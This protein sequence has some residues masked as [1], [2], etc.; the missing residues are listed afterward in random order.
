M[1]DETV[2]MQLEHTVGAPRQAR[3]FVVSTLDEW[4][5]T[6]LADDVA[7]LVSELVTNVVRHTEAGAMMRLT[8]APL[9]LRCSVI[10]DGGNLPHRRH[11]SPTDQSGRGLLLVE[12]I[13]SS[14]G[15]TATAGH[16]E[17]WFEVPI[18]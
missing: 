16:T 1:A 7:L 18:Q 14:W 5:L 3:R 6:H 8:R 15:S 17:V 10:D 12:T 9:H 4:G 13:A 11:P 2:T